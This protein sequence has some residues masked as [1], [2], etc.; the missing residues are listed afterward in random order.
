MIATPCCPKIG[1][2]G[3]AGLALPASMLSFIIVLTFF[4]IIVSLLLKIKI[5]PE[6]KFTLDFQ[7]NIGIIPLEIKNC[8]GNWE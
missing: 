8:N 6:M 4:A 3:G 5:R 7:W 1:P 2:I